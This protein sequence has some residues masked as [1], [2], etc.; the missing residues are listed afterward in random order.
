MVFFLYRERFAIGN[1]TNNIVCWHRR[2]CRDWYTTTPTTTQRLQ[3]IYI[4][5]FWCCVARQEMV[6]DRAWIRHLYDRLLTGIRAKCTDIEVCNHVVL[7][8]IGAE[9]D[10]N[11]DNRSTEIKNNVTMAT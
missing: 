4:F 8:V 9:I 5:Q 6:R 11:D 1:I 3:I 7:S 2:S 10:D